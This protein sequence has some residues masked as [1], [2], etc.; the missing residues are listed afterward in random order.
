[1][2][3]YKD[4][5]EIIGVYHKR[6]E[7]RIKAEME[8]RMRQKE[9]VISENIEDQKEELAYHT[10]M[11][12]IRAI[13][14]SLMPPTNVTTI[15]SMLEYLQNNFLEDQE[16]I[17]LFSDDDVN[18]FIL[19]LMQSNDDERI[20]SNIIILLGIVVYNSNTET[21]LSIYF[22][23]ILN[24]VLSKSTLIISSSL[25][26][27][28]CIIE[29][30][31]TTRHILA[32]HE[33]FFYTL[34]ELAKLP[35]YQVSSSALHIIYSFLFFQIHEQDVSPALP[36]E[37]IIQ[38][39]NI[40]ITKTQSNFSKQVFTVS[41][42]IL[43][44]LCCDTVML[45]RILSLGFENSLISISKSISGNTIGP[46]YSIIYN[47]L[48]YLIIEEKECILIYD[49][50]FFL[51]INIHLKKLN[52]VCKEKGV[53]EKRISSLDSIINAIDILI[54]HHWPIFLSTGIFYTLMNLTV[55]LSNGET[56]QHICTI[57][58]HIID[59]SD[60][61]TQKDLLT[62]EVLATLVKSLDSDDITVFTVVLS[63]LTKLYMNDNPYY[64]ELFRE[65]EVF[66]ILECLLNSSE[67]EFQKEIQ[68]AM[69]SFGFNDIL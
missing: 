18:Q 6:Y 54:P 1:M 69:S 33:S 60:I 32:D 9:F 36:I 42:E 43:L 44:M 16:K 58:C 45:E 13:N 17:S 37:L 55:Y 2:N 40:C 8:Y 14:N 52:M 29:K 56:S 63:T 31:P 11:E 61:S 15:I 4:D 41:L 12:N 68:W 50:S 62:K 24:A 53:N 28:D 48:A 26:A 21:N 3:S 57:F 64:D 38:I 35:N 65:N 10:L 51:N 49:Q 27:L 20:I 25:I 19:N 7:K 67:P 46:F 30:Y 59:F 39:Y 47:V 22:D 34:L 23:Y 5:I 66:E